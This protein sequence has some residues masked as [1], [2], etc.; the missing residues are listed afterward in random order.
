[1][2]D[3]PLGFVLR[4]IQLED[5]SMWRNIQEIVNMQNHMEIDHDMIRNKV[6]VDTC[7]RATT[8]CE[9]NPSLSCH[10]LYKQKSSYIPDNLRITFTRIRLS[11]H[12]LRVEVGRWS[13]TPR[14]KRL[15]P[16]GSFQDEEHLLVCTSNSVI[17]QNFEYNEGHLGLIHLFTKLDVKHLSMLKRLLDNIKC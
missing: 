11:S 15:C 4:L 16:C 14:E 10:Q 5:P 8:Y 1:M 9:L 12:R 13:R 3:D 17:L 2:E 6:K 7:R